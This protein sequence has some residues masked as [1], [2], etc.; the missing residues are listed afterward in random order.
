M[1]KGLNPFQLKTEMEVKLKIFFDLL[2]K[3]KTREAA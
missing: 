2:R 3:S 1:K